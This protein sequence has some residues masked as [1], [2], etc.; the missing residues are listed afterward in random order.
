VIT[1]KP[2]YRVELVRGISWK[3]RGGSAWVGDPIEVQVTVPIGVTGTLHL[4]LH[5]RDESRRAGV[6]ICDGA[7][8]EIGEHGG[9]GR[10][11][12]FEIRP[13]QT[14][15]GRIRVTCIRRSGPD[16]RLTQILFKPEG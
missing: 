7:R 15:D 12:A 3:D 10:W 5:D 2:G 16:L 13:E 4:H 9:G 6:V 8:R 11:I 1:G 14:R